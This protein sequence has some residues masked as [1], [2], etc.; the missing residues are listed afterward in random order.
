MAVLTYIILAIL[1]YLAYKLIIRK[2]DYFEKIGVK[3]VKPS[4]L[5]FKKR[6]L[7]EVANGWYNDFKHEK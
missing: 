1:S 7:P 3:F 4:P 2:N 5:L 6:S